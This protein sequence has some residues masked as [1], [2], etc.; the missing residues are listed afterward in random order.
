MVEHSRIQSLYDEIQMDVDGSDS[1][2]LGLKRRFEFD[3]DDSS[4]GKLF[5]SSSNSD[6]KVAGFKDSSNNASDIMVGNWFF[7]KRLAVNI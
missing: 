5:K 6:K 7:D 1:L 3:A 2:D 4:S